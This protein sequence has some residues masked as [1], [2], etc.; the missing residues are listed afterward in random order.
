MNRVARS[1]LL[2]L[3]ACALTAAAG[4][5]G[6]GEQ[7]LDMYAPCT[8][9]ED[10]GPEMICGL[11]LAHPSIPGHFCTRECSI[12]ESEAVEGQKCQD[13]SL[14]ETGCCWIT[15]TH[16]RPDAGE[17]TYSGLCVASAE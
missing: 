6:G 4:C 13:V 17:Y 12:L 9:D 10:C 15:S 1:T 16:A 8:L 11:A 2:A 7:G 14:C 3:I 5:D